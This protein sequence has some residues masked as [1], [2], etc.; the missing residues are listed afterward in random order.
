MSLTFYCKEEDNIKEESINNYQYLFSNYEKNLPSLKEALNQMFKNSNVEDVIV[1]ELTED[2]LDQCQNK[3]DKRY[4]EIKIK[5]DNITKEDAY[6]ICSYTCESLNPNFS[7]FRLLNQSLINDDRQRGIKNISKY[8]YILLKALRKLPRYYPK[9]NF[10]YRCLP[11]KVDISKDSNDE[12]SVPYKPGNLKTFWGFT[13]TSQEPKITYGFLK[14]KDGGKSGTIF[15]LGGD[16]W[17][18]DIELFNYFDEKEILLEP[19]RKLKVD[20]VLPPVNDV[21][22]IT[23]K[24]L[25]TPLVLSNSELDLNYYND[26]EDDINMNLTNV[27][28]MMNRYIIKYEIEATINEKDEF[29]SGIGVLCNIPDK[30]I[31]ALLTF[32]HFINLNFLNQSRKLI[33]YI[34]GKEI[35]ILMKKNRYKYSN[36]ELDFAIIEIL[37]N[38]GVE[39]FIGLDKFL[40]SRNYIGTDIKCLSLQKNKKIEMLNGIIE[41]KNND[42]YICSIDSN[43]EGI[44]MLKDNFKLIGLMKQNKEIIPMNIII[45]KINFIKCIYYIKNEEK[46]NYIQILNNKNRIGSIN[47]LEIEDKIKIMINGQIISNT[48]KFKF[49]KEGMQN[50]YLITYD[51]ITNMSVMFSDCTSL[52]EIDLESFDT[53]KVTNM[54]Y[55]FHNC[56]SLKKIN[57]SLFDTS[58]VT[59]MSFMFNNC[60]SLK[61]LNLTS[62]NTS[63]VTD[64]LSMFENCL[65]LDKLNLTSFNTKNVKDMSYMFSG[66]NSLKKLDLKSFNTEQVNNFSRMFNNCSSLKELNISSFK[67]DNVKDMSNMFNNCSSLEE[68]YLTIFNAI[69]VNNMS[70]M[71]YNCSSL[72]EL[73]FIE[74]TDNVKDMSKM[75]YNCSSIKQLN[76]RKFNTR[77]VKDMSCMFYN[78]SSLQEINLSSFSTYNVKNMSSMFNKCS[79]LKKLDLS[80]FDADNK[81]NMMHMFDSINIDCSIK[82]KNKNIRKEL[83]KFK[84]ESN[85]IRMLGFLSLFIIIMFIYK[86]FKKIF[87]YLKILK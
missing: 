36:E 47:N 17:G 60:F 62:F 57:I 72:K 61:D 71:F 79:S 70:G 30:R 18:Y 51:N 58:Q 21:I 54:A 46:D 6:I 67:T 53:S 1:N 69:N 26:I 43:N 25:K 3:I 16:I 19:E 82:C 56:Y 84:K 29:K 42:N 7:P 77:K 52:K 50:I 11:V 48:L 23:C 76:L 33:L 15:T 8:L 2:I 80:Y 37:E 39:N 5:Y 68:L 35:E 14:N 20:S 85:Y 81:V 49:N 22:N 64:M 65:S 32:N 10:L 55:M 66:C 28:V 44:I 24:I 12:K 4:N 38:D 27:G 41:G 63:K 9:N 87:H 59:D 75:F 86:L 83:K 31:K 34:N 73:F 78:C 13:S 40:N 45:N 74:N